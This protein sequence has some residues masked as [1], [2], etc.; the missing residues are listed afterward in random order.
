M[1]KD[2]IALHI[3]YNNRDVSDDEANFLKYYCEILDVPL[4]LKKIEMKR[5]ETD[6]KLYE[7]ITRDLRFEEYKNI[8][9]KYNVDGICLGH[10]EGDVVENVLN[11]FIHGKNVLDLKKM[12]KESVINVCKLWRPFLEIKK[13]EIFKF[14]HRYNV[15]YFK[16]TTPDWSCRG[17]M[18]NTIIPTLTQYHFEYFLSIF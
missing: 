18:R 15:P 13:D 1:R 4:I 16:N 3:N 17:R 11:N 8:I 7:S 5:D 12:T 9:K 10:H 14:A 6:R 2:V